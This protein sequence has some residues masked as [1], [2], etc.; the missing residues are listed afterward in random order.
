MTHPFR[1]LPRVDADNEFFWTSG[2]DGRLRFLRCGGC[3]YFVHPPGPVCPRCLG[4]E[5]APEA[6]GG[7]ATVFSFT[8]NHKAWAP[9]I[10][11][12]YVIAIVEL[13]EQE[14]LRLT[15]NI[16]NAGPDTVAIGMP[17]QVLFEDHDGVWIPVFEPAPGP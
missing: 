5:L 7:R 17:V 8:V 16:V 4:T 13:V 11:E 14:G 9:D 3:G 6:V 1:V 15:T 12:P 10:T 2:R